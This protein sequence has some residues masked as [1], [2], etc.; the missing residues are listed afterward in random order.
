[1]VAVL[2]QACNPTVD[3]TRP[4]TR[5]P[6]S[7]PTTPSPTETL[8]QDALAERLALQTLD[9]T[10]GP[11][12][13]ARILTLSGIP[14]VSARD[15]SLVNQPATPTFIDSYVYDIQVPMLAEAIRS[16]RTW[17][18]EDLWDVPDFL[19]PL[20]AKPMFGQDRFARA[21]QD[22]IQNALADPNAPGAFPALVVRQLSEVH[23]PPQNVFFH[24]DPNSFRVDP[25]QFAILAAQAMSRVGRVQALPTPTPGT[26]AGLVASPVPAGV[27]PRMRLAAV[28][29]HEAA[30]IRGVFRDRDLFTAQGDLV[31]D[32]LLLA[33]IHFG[34]S[35]SVGQRIR[36]PRSAA[37]PDGRYSYTATLRFDS[38]MPGEPIACGG[39]AGIELPE[40]GPVPGWVVAW[41]VVQDDHLVAP[42]TP[43]DW[44][45]LADGGVHGQLGFAGEPTA[46]DGTTTLGMVVSLDAG[47]PKAGT[48]AAGPPT[49]GTVDAFALIDMNRTAGRF[50]L[51]D[52]ITDFPRIEGP[53]LGLALRWRDAAI[54]EIGLPVAFLALTVAH[55]LPVG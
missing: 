30:V 42:A 52:L 54:D 16:N 17:F 4:S 7:S 47:C 34:A 33:G 36:A 50:T 46:A 22:W 53:T 43:E 13:V 29:G 23:A 48:C 31:A 8:D 40:N 32:I 24:L 3:T 26:C 27:D 1:M 18:L 51:G 5:P 21:L 39:L 25:L 38:S 14:I 10:T 20:V 2:L 9:P 15:G 44:Q 55:H 19:M 45:K 49:T 37:D 11:D 6:P 28:L 12:A 35:A 41:T